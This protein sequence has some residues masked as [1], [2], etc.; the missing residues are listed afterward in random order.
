[1]KPKTNASKLVNIRKL[2]QILAKRPGVN[3]HFLNIEDCILNGEGHIIRELLWNIR[4]AYKF[5]NKCVPKSQ[6]Q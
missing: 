5:M 6:Y 3:P 2:L 1:M 4:D